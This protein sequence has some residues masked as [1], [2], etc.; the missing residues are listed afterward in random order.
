MASKLDPHLNEV[1]ELI[2]KD[3]L[4]Q[5]QVGAKFGVARRTVS[6]FC[7]KNGIKAPDKS[8][9]TKEAIAAL[10]TEEVSQEEILDSQNR[11]LKA[12]LRKKQKESVASARIV[13]AV[14]D[15]LNNIEPRRKFKAVEP[16]GKDN[17]HHRQM[18]LLSDFHGGEYVYVVTV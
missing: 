12:A 16:K 11:E 7:K 17:A 18:V 14:E 13:A 15:A 10:E 9:Y 2:E 3:G 4:T 8:Y 1:R 6:D 5:I